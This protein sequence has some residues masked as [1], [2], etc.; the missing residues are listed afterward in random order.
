MLSYDYRSTD[1]RCRTIYLCFSFSPSNHS[2]VVCHRTTI[3]RLSFDCRTMSY[4]I[5]RYRTISYD[6]VRCRTMS[7][8]FTEM[9]DVSQTHRVRCDRTTKIAISYPNRGKFYKSTMSLIAR[10]R[11]P[12]WPRL[13]QR[14][15]SAT[16]FHATEI[17]IRCGLWERHWTLQNSDVSLGLLSSCIISVSTTGWQLHYKHVIWLY[18]EWGTTCS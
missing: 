3:V 9:I 5:V 2:E 17:A 1:V 15:W 4:D 13:K 8:D 7:Y 10:R 14:V 12:V 16:H 11:S 6:V 18:E